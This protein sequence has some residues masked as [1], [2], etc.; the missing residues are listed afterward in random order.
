MAET[1][2][3]RHLPVKT[4]MKAGVWWASACLDEHVDIYECCVPGHTPTNCSSCIEN[5]VQ[6]NVNDYSEDSLH[7]CILN[8]ACMG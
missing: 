8:K 6:A 2:Q 3:I 5:C 7:Q 1:L 4:R